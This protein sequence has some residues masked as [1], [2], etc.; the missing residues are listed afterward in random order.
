MTLPLGQRTLRERRAWHSLVDQAAESK[1]FR[2]RFCEKP[3]TLR[4]TRPSGDLAAALQSRGFSDPAHL[5]RW[6]R[7]VLL[8][9]HRGHRNRRIRHIAAVA[10]GG[11]DLVHHVHALR[12]LAED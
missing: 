7:S 6:R 11:D 10:W 2:H 5:D 8:D 9:G 12:H 1:G 3:L 4:T